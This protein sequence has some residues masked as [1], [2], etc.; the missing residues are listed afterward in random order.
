MNRLSIVTLGVKDMKRSF[1]FYKSM[2]F[3]TSKSLEE[4]SGM[5]IFDNE[6]S[7]LALYP[8]DALALDIHLSEPPKKIGFSGITIAYNVMTK[9]EV[10]ETLDRAKSL[11]G[12]IIK[13]AEQVFWGGYSGYFSDPDGYIFEVAY[14][15]DFTY[16]KQNMLVV[17]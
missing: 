12:K 4:A 7:K 11:G 10:N 5:V 3:K 2:G 15:E 1:S 16:D 17:D 13:E 8:L 9:E 6:G 14:A